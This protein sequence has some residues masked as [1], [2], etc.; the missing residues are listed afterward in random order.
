MKLFVVRHD[1]GALSLAKAHD[2]Q[3]AI[4][5]VN[6]AGCTWPAVQA[7]E[8]TGTVLGVSYLR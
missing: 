1:L 2:E 5:T 6:E 3:D 4:N 7:W 8:W